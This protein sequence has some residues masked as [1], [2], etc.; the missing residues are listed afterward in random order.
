MPT[1][2]WPENRKGR[3]HLEDLRR[4]R[5]DIILYLEEMW[6]NVDRIYLIFDRYSDELQ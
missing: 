4:R 1:T 5:E 3:D 2:Y 6:W